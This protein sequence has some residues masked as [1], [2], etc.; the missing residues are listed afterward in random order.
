MCD[1]TAAVEDWISW[2]GDPDDWSAFLSH[3]DVQ[4]DVWECPHDKYDGFDRCVFHI[5]P[6]QMPEDLDEAQ[7]LTDAVIAKECTQFI[8]A[9]FGAIEASEISIDA[10]QR[11]FLTGSSFSGLQLNDVEF[12]CPV[13]LRYV[14]FSGES[15]FHETIFEEESDFK[16]SVFDERVSFRGSDF[17]D[18][19]RFSYARFGAPADFSYAHFRDRVAFGNTGF[20]EASDFTEAVFEGRAMFGRVSFGSTSIF[21]K[22]VY[23]DEAFFFNSEFDGAFFTSAEFGDE[24]NFEGTSFSGGGT[25]SEVEFSQGVNFDGADLSDTDFS[26]LDLSG[27]SFVDAN[28]EYVSFAGC[29]IADSNFSG[30]DL[31]GSNLERAKLTDS[32]LFDV[33]LSGARIYG[34]RLGDAAINADT[35]F[36]RHGEYRCVYDPHSRY[37]YEGQGESVSS[38]QKAMNTYHLLENLTRSNTLPDE[39][40]K[41]FVRRQDMRREQ[42][43]RDES[44]PRLK[45]W[46]AEAQNAIFRHGESFS[47]VVACSLG[48]VIL[49]AVL[50]PLG[51]WVSNQDGAITYADIAES[52]QLV[53][54]VFNHSARLF[55]T[56]GGPLESTSIAGEVL[57]TAET[58]IAPILLALLVFVLGRRAA[59]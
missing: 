43:R 21:S 40:S 51:G 23:E 42:L 59:R 24:A 26:N 52:P 7:M 38:V 16:K 30:A 50:Y 27:S 25:F 13:D 48:T 12:R 20:S 32:N 18:D 28:A 57:T 10:N 47:R 31:S 49:F 6:D 39:Q 22:T 37:G 55:L 3:M 11:L 1:Y 58:M 15:S 5:P 45:Y 53:W 36:D 14:R 4:G 19:T 9:D 44:P 46:F 35:V 56:G 17:I 2:G 34:T 54:Q 33:D 8:G 41:F 29:S